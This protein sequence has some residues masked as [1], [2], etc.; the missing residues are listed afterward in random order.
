MGQPGGRSVFKGGQKLLS[1]KETSF[2]LRSYCTDSYID[3]NF[4]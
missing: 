1:N 4:I 3:N 2:F